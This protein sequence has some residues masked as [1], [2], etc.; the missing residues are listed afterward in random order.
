MPK[1]AEIRRKG[2]MAGF[3]LLL[4]GEVFPWHIERE[5]VDVV[6]LTGDSAD[7]WYALRF[8]VIIGGPVIGADEFNAYLDDEADRSRV[9]RADQRDIVLGA[10]GRAAPTVPAGCIW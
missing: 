5:A 8:G 3:E 10:G 1:R 4:D 7:P 9:R 2:D 6:C